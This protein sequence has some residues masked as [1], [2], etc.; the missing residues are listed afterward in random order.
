MRNT[1]L[2]ADPAQR[3]WIAGDSYIPGVPIG[4][5]VRGFAFGEVI[6]SQRDDL[7]VGEQVVGLLGWQTHALVGDGALPMPT[8][9]PAGIAPEL[10]LGVLGPTGMTA[11]FGL[12]DIGQPKPGETVV[13]SAAAG[14][15]GSVVGQIAKI[16]GCRVVGIAGGA[17]KARW[18]LDDLGFDAAIDYK[19]DDL[20]QRL[21]ETCPD[22]VHVYFDNVGGAV[23]DAVLPRLAIG[24]RVVLCGSISRYDGAADAPGIKNL[25]FA[26]QQRARLQGFIILDYAPRAME[27]LAPML[28]WVQ[29]GRLKQ[30]VD[31]LVGLENAP[32]ALGRLFAG[33]NTGKQ[34]V[35]L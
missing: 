22:G 17:E 9:V 16:K 35:K 4:E 30:R 26:T 10:A 32:E 11:Y 1:Y 12:L 33:R 14:A 2:S 3:G 21:R 18:L 6:A 7:A 29:E 31:V 23:L 15:T 25:S 13:V 34:L 19:S 8:K 24:G 5:V 28:A 27:A 20:D